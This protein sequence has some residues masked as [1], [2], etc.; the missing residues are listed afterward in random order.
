[1]I[2]RSRTLIITTRA[3][4]LLIQAYE[5]FKR[6]VRRSN[7]AQSILSFDLQFGFSTFYPKNEVNF[8]ISGIFSLDSAI[9][10]HCKYSTYTHIFLSY[11]IAF[12]LAY[13]KVILKQPCWRKCRPWRFTNS[14]ISCA[15][16]I[17]ITTRNSRS[18]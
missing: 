12:C 7:N 14:R 15:S 9:Q 5:S 1:M 17:I 4:L 10:E 8:G 18:L 2:E 11:Q 16:A 6:N 3:D 13:F